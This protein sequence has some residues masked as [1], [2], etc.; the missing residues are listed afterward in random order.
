MAEHSYDTP[1]PTKDRPRAGPSDQRAFPNIQS[2]RYKFIS[3][4]GQGGAGTVFHALDTVLNKEVAIK[5]LHSASAD[6]AIRFQREAK[7]AGALR[8]ENVL[9]ALDFGVTGENQ[10][11]LILDYESGESLAS[12]I[13][14]HG[15][16][17][18]EEALKIAVQIAAG[19]HHAH[20]NGVIH[21]D[22]KPSNVILVEKERSVD[23]RSGSREG[24]EKASVDLVAKIVDFGLAKSVNEVQDVTQ[25]GTGLGTPK[26]MSPEQVHGVEVDERSDIYSFGCLM[27]EI[28]TGRVPFR[29]KTA[30][31]TLDMHLNMPPPSVAD[32]GVDCSENLECIIDRCLNKDPDERFQSVGYLLE[33]LKDELDEIEKANRRDAAMHA[34]DDDEASKSNSNYVYK[35][36]NKYLVTLGVLS[37][38]MIS[39]V[40]ILARENETSE[41]KT[42]KATKRYY[43]PENILRDDDSGEKIREELGIMSDGYQFRTAHGANDA[44]L[45]KFLATG[46]NSERMDSL[47]ASDSSFTTAGFKMLADKTK[48][49]KLSFAMQPLTKK[50]LSNIALIPTLVDIRLGGDKQKIAPGTFLQL[51]KLGDL[52]TLYIGQMS[53]SERNFE[54]LAHIKKL[55]ILQL[56]GCTG[57]NSAG[58]KHLSKSKDLEILKLENT[59]IDDDALTV[60]ARQHP[61]ICKL[62]L[63]GTGLTDK[64]IDALATLGN[65][66]ELDVQYCDGVTHE[67]V[68]RLKRIRPKSNV[69]L[70]VEVGKPKS[71]NIE[72]LDTYGPELN[73]NELGSH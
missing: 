45:K 27:F 16:L 61:R 12:Y 66:Q 28:L 53:L 21:R 29:G 40:V 8:H 18:V 63:R 57:I 33:K 68:E 72:G 4:I 9:N 19:L 44:D 7:L 46:T 14:K 67:G 31:E 50:T 59:D 42:R 32:E 43:S 58:F 62:V 60:L 71:D 55:K 52:D 13:K 25:V 37:L 6:Q 5:K 22:I 48:L 65:L 17:E 56:T 69:G 47:D 73:F 39:T 10:P 64:S 11:Y 23:I 41:P 70:F 26:Y 54:E 38:I 1:T 51:E 2:G 30:L 35:K 24:E 3:V 36:S 15:M 49:T 20:K 34:E